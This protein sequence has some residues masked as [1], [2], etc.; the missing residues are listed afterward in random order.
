MRGDEIF[1]RIGYFTLGVVAVTLLADGV[2]I[3]ASAQASAALQPSGWWHH[4]KFLA[5]FVG[6]VVLGGAFGLGLVQRRALRRGVVAA[7]GG[8]AAVIAYLTGLALAAPLGTTLSLLAMI[9][10]AAAVPPLAARFAP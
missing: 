1:T 8:L 3:A 2:S 5:T 7:L 9:V 10:V 4:A 6:L